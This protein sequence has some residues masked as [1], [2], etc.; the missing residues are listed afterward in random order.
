MINHEHYKFTRNW[1]D[2]QHDVVPY[3]RK[4]IKDNDYRELLEVGTFE[5]RSLL[6]FLRAGITN[7]CCIDIWEVR[8]SGENFQYNL[9]L[10]KSNYPWCNIYPMKGISY[11]Q[12]CGLITNDW[13]FDLVYIDAS[14]YAHNTLLDGSLAF[15]MLRKGGCIIFD[16]YGWKSEKI[17]DHRS[18]RIGID[19]FEKSYLNY[20]E[21]AEV[22]PYQ[23][24][25]YKTKEVDLC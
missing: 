3:W 8:D 18:A 2:S 4:I 25:W 13:Q 10:F 15:R 19:Q 6:H 24:A 7:I 12:L 22:H 20:I 21:P 23:R 1:V 5:G 16:D 11:E 9:K 14:H 17:S